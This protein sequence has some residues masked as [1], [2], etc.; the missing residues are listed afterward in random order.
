[1]KGAQADKTVGLSVTSAQR[2]SA[3]PDVPT[4]AEAGFPGFG[5]TVW[6]GVWTPAKTPDSVVTKI[7]ADIAGSLA[8][9]ELLTPFEKRKLKPMS[10]SP[11]EFSR[12]VRTEWESA[13]RVFKQAREAA[14]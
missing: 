14:K 7:A 13:E 8:T 12:F 11:A 2:T 1:L 6:W 4:V 9:P 5:K 3:M 10:M